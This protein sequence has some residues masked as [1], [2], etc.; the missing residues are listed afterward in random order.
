VIDAVLGEEKSKEDF[1]VIIS[2][3]ELAEFFSK[4]K[5]PVK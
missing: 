3:T 2:S 4:D 5:T 1:D